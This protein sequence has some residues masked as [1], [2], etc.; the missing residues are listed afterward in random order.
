MQAPIGAELPVARC[1][2]LILWRSGLPFRRRHVAGGDGV[3]AGV[4]SGVAAG[5]EL[6]VAVPRVEAGEGVA[7]GEALAFAFACF[8]L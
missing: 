4:I 1:E 3:D 6:G 2:R 7:V 5:E 8:D